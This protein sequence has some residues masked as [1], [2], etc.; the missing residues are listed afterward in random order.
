MSFHKLGCFF[1][2]HNN[3]VYKEIELKDCRDNS[4]GIVIINRC[5]DCGKIHETKV[6]NVVDIRY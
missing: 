1:G 5:K 6:Y 3:E 2:V 4:V